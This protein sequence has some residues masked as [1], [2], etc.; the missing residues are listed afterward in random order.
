[1]GGYLLMDSPNQRVIKTELDSSI[2][3]ADL[4]SIAECAAAAHIATIKNISFND[5]CLEQFEISSQYVCT[6]A[7]KRI[8]ECTSSPK[9]SFIM[10]TSKPISQKKY[11]SMMDIMDKYYKNVGTFGVFVDNSVMM[12]GN[13]GKRTI[14]ENIRDKF[15]ITD[16]QLVYFT[17][18]D[19]PQQ[20]TDYITTQSN[21]DIVCPVGTTKTYRFR[22]WQCIPV[23]NKTACSGDRIWDSEL[24]ECVPDES[25]RPLCETNQTAVMVEN[26]WECINPFLDKTCPDGMIARLNYEKLEWECLEDPD[27]KEIQTKCSGIQYGSLSGSGSNTLTITSNRCNDCETMIIDEESC[28]AYCMPDAT[29]LNNDACYKDAES[30]SDD[31]KAIYF[32]F[33][34]SKYSANVPQVQDTTIPSGPAYSQNRRFNCMTCDRGVNYDKSLIPYIVICN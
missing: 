34:S 20:Q 2:S 9:F 21:N 12:A 25:K 10:T 33:P 27:A 6:N 3:R 30:C 13:T 29:K 14:P 26:I 11:N 17:N 32:G 19:I 24:Y 28:T 8:V 15:N 16:G 31:D 22:R 7:S 1:M 5:P 23:N 4:R 18:S